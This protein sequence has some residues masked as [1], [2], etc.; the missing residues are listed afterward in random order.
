MRRFLVACAT[1]LTL[2][3]S[4]AFACGQVGPCEDVTPGGKKEIRGYGYGFEGGDRPV[5]LKWGA[6][7]SV[8]AITQIDGNGNFRAVIT[9]P[10]KI[11]LHKLVVYQGDYDPDPVVVSI[12]VVAPWYLRPLDALQSAV[13]FQNSTTVGLILI[14]I[15][16]LIFGLLPMLRRRPQSRAVQ[17]PLIPGGRCSL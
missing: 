8:A 6:D 11:G 15:G 9:A 4:A 10:D 7:G 13:S 5:I 3:S 2:V 12:P 1:F 16:I 14:G 17:N